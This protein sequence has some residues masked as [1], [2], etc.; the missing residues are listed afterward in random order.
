MVFGSTDVELLLLSRRYSIISPKSKHRSPL[1][2]NSVSTQPNEKMSICG[3]SG[4]SRVVVG[5]A[6]GG[7][8]DEVVVGL[9]PS[10]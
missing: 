2:N 7:R 6:R 3:V 8:D 5:V 9:F 4:G 10:S 1:Q